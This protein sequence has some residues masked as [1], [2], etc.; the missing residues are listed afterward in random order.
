MSELL[1]SLAARSVAS[2]IVDYL[3]TTFNLTDPWARRT[4]QEFLADPHDGMFKGPYVRLRLPFRPAADGWRDHL[5]WHPA[6]S[7]GTG[8]FAPYGHQA[9]AYARLSSATLDEQRP[10]PLP[11]LVTTG[12]GSGKTEAF[13]HPILDHVLRER[14]KGNGGIKALLLYPM[15]A[16]ANDQSQRLAELITTTPALAGVTA[17]LYT[18]E[19]DQGRTAV[20]AD[21]L[22]TSRAV[23]RSEAPDILLTNYKMLDQ[24]LLRPEDQPLWAQSAN[25]LQYLVLDE[26]HTYDG[27]QGTD[28]AMLLRR[29]G[30]VLKANGQQPLPGEAPETA[31]RPLGHVTPVATS[32]TL[33]DEGD[34]T[35]MLTFAE[36]VFGEPFTLDAVVT[37]SRLSLEEWSQAPAGAPEPAEGRGLAPRLT[38]LTEQFPTRGASADAEALTRAVLD[39]LHVT[40]AEGVDVALTA[41]LTPGELLRAH[42]LVIRLVSLCAEAVEH[43]EVA[44]ELFP[45]TKDPSHATTALDLLLAALSHVRS[46][47]GRSMASVEIHL[48]VR[49]LSRIDRAASPRPAFSWSDDGRRVTDEEHTDAWFPAIW[50]RSC[51][52]SGWSVKVSPANASELDVTDDDIRKASMA[53]EGRVRALMHA[54]LAVEA[55]ESDESD[56]LVATSGSG[57]TTGVLRW[58]HPGRR[59]FLTTPP[60]GEEQHDGSVLPV[61]MHTGIDAG[62][63]NNKDVCPSCGQKDSVRFLGSAL[64]TQ[65]S[66]ALSTLFG[67]ADLD[68]SEK[69]ALVFTDSVQD[70]A[71]RAGFVQSRSHSLTLRSVL[72]RAVGEG[73]TLDRVATRAVEQAGDES[74]DRHR[75]LPPDLAETA[76]FRSFWENRKPSKATVERVRNRL[77]FDAALEFGLQSQFG[78]TLEQTSTVSVEVDAA[79]ETL[80][81]AARE[82]IESAGGLDLFPITPT[83][84]QMIV[85]ARGMLE[86]MRRRGAIHHPW[87]EKVIKE[88]GNRH[89]VWGGRPR[90]EGMPAF[91]TGRLA[92]A[93]PFVG[94]HPGGRE[95]IFD[96]TTTPK[97][98]YATWTK[99]C[100]GIPDATGSHL[101]GPLLARLA[102]HGVL[103]ER[104]SNSKLRVYA[105]PPTRVRLAPVDDTDLAVG[106]HT[107]RCTTCRST[108]AG[109]LTTVAQIAGGP[110]TVARCPGHLE[111][112]AGEPDNFYRRFFAAHQVQRVIAREHTSLLPDD[113]RL[114][115]EDG[116]KGSADTPNAPNVL[117]ATPT[118]EMG[119]DIGDL[120][121]V[122]LASLP[123]TVASYLQRVGRAGRLTGSALDLAF[124]AGRGQ[125]LPR[126][127]DPLSMINGEVRPPATY[128]KAEE[129]LRRQYIASVGDRLARRSDAPSLHGAGSVLSKVTPGTYLHDLVTFAEEDAALPEGAGSH[130]D[131]F[132]DAFP[133]LDGESRM[134]LRQWLLPVGDVPLTS[135][136][137]TRALSA[138]QQWKATLEELSHR[139]TALEADLPELK[140]KAAAETRTQE[141]EDALRDAEAAR[142]LARG[143]RAAMNSDHW[144]G[145]LE[146][147]GLFPNYTLHDDSVTL[148]VGLTWFDPDEAKYQTE[149]ASYGRASSLA[150][151]D[152]APGAVFYAGGHQLRVDT[153]DLGAAGSEVHTWCFCPDCGYGVDLTGAPVPT[154]CPRCS[155]N[156][157]ADLDQRLQ[158]AELTKV[159]SRMRRDDAVIDDVKEDRERIAFTQLV[160][161]DVDPAGET[162]RWYVEDFGLGVRHL[163]NM[164][165][166]WLNLGRSDASGKPR[167]LAGQDVSVP[168]FRLCAECGHIDKGMRRNARDEHQ[169]WCR[170][171]KA[172]EE[173]SVNVALSR[174]LVTEG[175]LVRLPAFIALGSP[176][177][178]PSLAAA[179]RLGLREH[180]GGD[181]DHLALEVVVDPTPGEGLNA[182]ALLVHDVVPGGTG[183]LAEL[184][185]HLTLRSILMKAYRVVAD[186]ACDDGRLAC[187]RCLLPLA[188]PGQENKVSRVEAVRVLRDL[189]NGDTGTS[190][191]PDDTPWSVTD[192]P[193]PAADLESTLEQKFR[194]VF[195]QRVTALGATLKEIPGDRGVSIE[196]TLGG[197]LWRLEPQVNIATSKPDFVLTCSDVNVPR[198]AI[199]CDGWQY[200]ASPLHNSIAVDAQKRRQLRDLDLQ[201]VSLSWEDLEDDVE[202]AWFSDAAW[203]QLTRR[204]GSGLRPEHRDVILNGP[205]GL[206]MHWIQRRDVDGLRA[207]GEALPWLFY[208]AAA[209]TSGAGR[210]GKTGRR[211]SLDHVALGVAQGHEPGSGDVPWW[212]WK[213]SALDVVCRAVPSSAAR[214]VELVLLCH[215]AED[216]L[217]QGRPGWAEWLRLSNLAGLRYS[218]TSVVARSEIDG[219]ETPP[220]PLEVMVSDELTVDLAP[221]WETLMAETTSDA[222]RTFLARLSESGMPIPT[223]DVEID[224]LPLGLAW[225]EHHVFVMN[226]DD[227]T[228]DEIAMLRERGWTPA[229]MDVDAVR[230]ALTPGGTS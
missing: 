150:L 14:K 109:S 226:P 180:I 121:T 23:M 198:T 122:M 68:A 138:A 34:P 95:P 131:E 37:E 28:V 130:L 123:R 148:D 9:A 220:P 136:L 158:V 51:G 221:E 218:H 77:A 145:V 199:F 76:Q 26:F 216:V 156:G 15:N 167:F 36:T 2:G 118:L 165:I 42:P 154:S 104:V 182:D 52:H 87:L 214:A 196:I 174:T 71:H 215:D 72:H 209:D 32:A 59:Q 206:L 168:L 129:I 40:G 127:G 93:F 58:F 6:D 162:R 189:L 188:T 70:A 172:E 39:V 1:P 81:T 106:R 228:D 67:D 224:G 12:T 19:G 160:A 146:R 17:G 155:S 16:L 33:G 133:S 181:P 44:D 94:K 53:K 190:H 46:T 102:Q 197:V 13:L 56:L 144:I 83:D 96:P 217:V 184:A 8:G 176:F 135:G 54:A 85:W 49:E 11:T 225:S 212:S 63:H 200:H 205:M 137:G 69:K 20:S 163:R 227:F 141:D 18:G 62:E 195:K 45:G 208:V 108:V 140:A 84:A 112:V 159:S 22:I 66:V 75:L 48:W 29:L 166:R 60:E 183:Y 170:L 223:F 177:V 7:P 161:A 229:T 192:V 134:R 100:L 203:Q 24:L 25:S 111:T 41:G 169:P 10:R 57:L 207:I 98:W 86:H 213:Q 119:I 3:D 211:S 201:V 21:G 173:K 43:R 142:K 149:T 186:C 139:I 128:L 90:H 80:V 31:Q 153:V 88:D 126:L 38:A 193:P 78:R 152:F 204:P 113:V 97:S 175:L 79:P 99:R 92:P 202:P 101:V 222:E 55:D 35:T 110:C 47:E 124:V 103:V 132:L 107:L 125:H 147:V 82:A 164:T 191:E 5:G 143:Q 50:C 171:R 116:F 64:T 73:T 105:V 65:L 219:V 178:I 89:F 91:P 185:D 27:A 115:H 117:V 120:S 61:L 151:R 114:A 194:E 157:I 210:S 74:R 30:M 230:H 187:H 179:L 4:V